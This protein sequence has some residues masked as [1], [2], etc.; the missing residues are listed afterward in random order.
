MSA[1][2]RVQKLIVSAKP[3]QRVK[4][5]NLQLLETA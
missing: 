3:T 4:T 2:K 5:I 1:E